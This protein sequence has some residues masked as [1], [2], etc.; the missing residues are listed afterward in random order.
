MQIQNMKWTREPKKYR[1]LPDRIEITTDRPPV[2]TP[3]M[4]SIRKNCY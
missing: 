3:I 1:I 4:N 2:T